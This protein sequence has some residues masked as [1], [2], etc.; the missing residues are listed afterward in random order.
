M[1]RIIKCSSLTVRDAY[2]NIYSFERSGWFDSLTLEINESK[3]E[4]RIIRE[5]FLSSRSVSFVSDFMSYQYEEA[6]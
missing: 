2:D 3:R 5:G 6:A 4:A 1:E